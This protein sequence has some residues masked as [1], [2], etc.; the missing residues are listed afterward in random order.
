LIIVLALPPSKLEMTLEHIEIRRDLLRLRTVV[1]R[2]GQ[3]EEGP[4]VLFVHLC[5][6]DLIRRKGDGGEGKVWRE[7][8]GEEVMGDE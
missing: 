1:L 5:Q 7:G 4:V 8:G 2:V 3:S 6:R